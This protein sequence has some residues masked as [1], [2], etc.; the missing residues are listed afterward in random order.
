M[1][2]K[3]LIII[4]NYNRNCA[5][6]ILWFDSEL[7]YK[8]ILNMAQAGDLQEKNDLKTISNSIKL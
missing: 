5:T 4:I 1:L 8:K 2:K 3:K 6:L 7:L